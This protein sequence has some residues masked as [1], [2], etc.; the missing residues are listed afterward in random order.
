MRITRLVATGDNRTGRNTAC[1]QDGRI[2]FGPENFGSQRFAVPAQSFSS[3]WFRRFQNFDAALESFLGNSQGSA[4]HFDFLFRFRL[5]LRPEKSVRR[6][7]T[8]LVCGEFLRVTE[9]KVCRDNY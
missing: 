5:A 8:D 9:C 4:H 3:A 7:D 2:N 6:A 1:A